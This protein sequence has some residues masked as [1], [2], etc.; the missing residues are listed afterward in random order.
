MIW[1]WALVGR[2]STEAH[3][4]GDNLRYMVSV[5]VFTG[6]N[7]EACLVN[8][9]QCGVYPTRKDHVVINIE[10]NLKQANGVRVDVMGPAEAYSAYARVNPAKSVMGFMPRATQ[11]TATNNRENDAFERN[12][13]ESTGIGLSAGVGTSGVFSAALAVGFTRTNQF[14]RVTHQWDATDFATPGSSTTGAP[15]EARTEIVAKRRGVLPGLYT[16]EEI[17]W[18]SQRLDAYGNG[19]RSNVRQFI[20]NGRY[21]RPPTAA[22]RPWT[23]HQYGDSQLLAGIGRSRMQY[24]GWNPAISSTFEV[25]RNRIIAGAA[26]NQFVDVSAGVTLRRPIY[27]MMRTNQVFCSDTRKPNSWGYVM[28]RPTTGAPFTHDASPGWQR[29]AGDLAYRR[30]VTTAGVNVRMPRALFVN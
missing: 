27:H 15:F 2:V 10:P 20:V 7:E 28:I 30:H 5:D 19:G 18:P 4:T 24:E 14:R 16:N 12:W 1:G 26:G 23:W 21:C 11:W 25:N 8:G 13:T 17:L 29:P 22:G 9:M 6:N 3:R